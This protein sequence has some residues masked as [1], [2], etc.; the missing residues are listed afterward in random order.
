[1]GEDVDRRPRT[2]TT[3]FLAE[4]DKRVYRETRVSNGNW[5][6]CKMIW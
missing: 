2:K 5:N 1:M 3:F 4:M 6:D